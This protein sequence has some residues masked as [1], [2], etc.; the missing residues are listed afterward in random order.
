[1]I[2]TLH[3]TRRRI[4]AFFFACAVA[5]G[6][7]I[8]VAAA[9]GAALGGGGLI[10]DHHSPAA[11]LALVSGVFAITEAGDASQLQ[12][13]G[14]GVGDTITAEWATSINGGALQVS[15][16][17]G[18][19]QAADGYLL[20]PFASTQPAAGTYT[21][22]AFAW[23]GGPPAACDSNGGTVT[24]AE[25]ALGGPIGDA[26]VVTTL[27][28]DYTLPCGPTTYRGEVRVASTQPYAAVAWESPATLAVPF[29]VNPPSTIPGRSTRAASKLTNIGNVDLTLGATS[30]APVSPP[31]WKVAP[32]TTCGS[33]LPPGQSCE[34][35]EDA[36]SWLPRPDETVLT[37]P[38]SIPGGVLHVGLIPIV[39]P[40]LL[41]PLVPNRIVDSRAGLGIT[42]VLKSR[43]ARVF[44]I[45]DRLPGDPTRN[46]PADAVAVVGN[47]TVT[48]QTGPGYLALT[49]T[50]TSAPTTSSLNFPL[51]DSRANGVVV[52][53]GPGGKAGLTYVGPAGTTAHVVFD[54]TGYFSGK[55]M[56]A[57]DVPADPGACGVSSSVPGRVLDTRIGLGLKGPF[58]AGVPRSL[59]LPLIG[60]D[61][62]A[63]AVLGNITVVSPSSG[64]YLSVTP[65]RPTGVPRTSTINVPAGDTRANNFVVQRA[66]DGTI[67]IT[68][69]AKAGATANVIVDLSAICGP[70]MTGAAGFVPL[71]PNRIVDSRIGLQIKGRR[72]IHTYA[73][74]DVFDRFPADP[75]R[76]VPYSALS[77]HLIGLM[78]NLTMVNQAS[79][80]W[81]AIVASGKVAT[82]TVNAP[83]GDTRANGFTALEGGGKN[84]YYGASSDALVDLLGYWYTN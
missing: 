51:R 54:V 11:P 15:V 23:H 34:L 69:V 31:I 47:L 81:L 14:S 35:D 80:G 38:I 78:G 2:A 68:F 30:F 33:S 84:V 79:A 75:S 74:F 50:A 61:D 73:Y 19:G 59:V 32:T 67:A 62:Q 63:V 13:W 44:T 70:W 4:L 5:A 9:R 37:L 12:S 1:M 66:G 39:E 8:P 25:I 71:N 10:A 6:S 53:L 26:T 49:T 21:D 27:A 40:S 29:R 64:G 60:T 3:G 72:P 17:D 56:G 77:Q 41:I 16:H 22:V 18:S 58:V 28:L 45:V 43:V 52:R 57:P 46:V 82:S 76:D 48:G 7:A 55:A 36:M 20:V 65:T 83:H 42:S 24:I